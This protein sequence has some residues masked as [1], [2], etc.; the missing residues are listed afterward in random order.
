MYVCVCVCIDMNNTSVHI[1]SVCFSI[2]Y[3]GKT[4]LLLS[5]NHSRDLDN[6]NILLCFK[7]SLLKKY[8]KFLVGFYLFFFYHFLTSTLYYF[9]TDAKHHTQR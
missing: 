3:S 9:S 6:L 1:N 8:L 5:G 4:L 7:H 2:I